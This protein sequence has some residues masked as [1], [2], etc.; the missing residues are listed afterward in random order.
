MNQITPE[1]LEQIIR[2]VVAEQL[3]KQATAA[4]F[5]KHSDPS[6]VAVIKAPTVK[7]KPFDTGNPGDKV[8]ITDILDLDES[9]RL[10]CGMMEI[11]QTTFDWTLEYDEVD[12]IVE[13]TLKIIIDGREVVGHAGDV[14]FIPKGTTIQ[15]SAPDFARFMFVAYPANWEEIARQK[16]Q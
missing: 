13:G 6:G 8:F 5:D 4:E 1:A 2:K 9:P 10:G 12:Y 15:F 7:C 16:Q 11:H 14:M 3:T